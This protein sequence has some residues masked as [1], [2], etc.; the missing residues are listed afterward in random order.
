MTNLSASSASFAS[1][2]L[3]AIE[4]DFYDLSVDAKTVSGRI[5]VHVAAGDDDS[6][7]EAAEAA[8]KS[9]KGDHI[10]ITGASWL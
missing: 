5:V 6:E 4:V 9:I 10:V 8:A 1:S 2:A 7:V 3:V